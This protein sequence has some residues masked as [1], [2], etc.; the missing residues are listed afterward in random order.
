MFTNWNAEKTPQN[1]SLQ[2]A[3]FSLVGPCISLQTYSAIASIWHPTS[4]QEGEDAAMYPK[5]TGSP[6][7]IGGSNGIITSKFTHRRVGRSG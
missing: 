5:D 4:N 6:T 3:D 2:L 1:C 7:P